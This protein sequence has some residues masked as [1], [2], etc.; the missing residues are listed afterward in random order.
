MLGQIAPFETLGRR[1]KP[2]G[3]VR[4]PP[5]DDSDSAYQQGVA[6]QQQYDLRDGDRG[7]GEGV[8]QS[9]GDGEH[10]P[11]AG[12]GPEGVD[13]GG[14]VGPERP[15]DPPCH[16][17][18]EHA[19]GDVD[20][21]HEDQLEHSRERA[22]EVDDH[23]PYTEGW[24]GHGVLD[25]ERLES[26][27]DSELYGPEGDGRDCQAQDDVECPYDSCDSDPAGRALCC[28]HHSPYCASAQ[29]SLRGSLPQALT[30]LS[31]MRM[32]WA[33]PAGIMKSSLTSMR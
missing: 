17:I 4:E 8:G 21:R 3:A 28:S 27:P 23:G 20:E 10:D 26:L 19:A 11:H 33:H 16:E 5:N 22:E 6:Q 15:S 18:A 12:S 7:E 29:P 25:N 30:P 32:S 24:D 31:R 2:V 14:E 1:T 13:Q 9:G